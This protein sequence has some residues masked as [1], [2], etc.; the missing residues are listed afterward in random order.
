MSSPATINAS[1]FKILVV[2]EGGVGKTTFIKRHR[3]GEFEKKYVATMGVEVNPLHLNTSIGQI[4]FNSW[5]C[6]GQEKF[7]GLGSGYYKGAHAAI[8]MFDVTS[9]TSYKSVPFWY[10]SV[11]AVCPLIPIVLC[12][13]K[14]DCKDRKVKPSEIQFHRKKKIQYYDISA[15]SNYNFEKPFLYLARCLTGEGSLNFVESP[16]V[17]PPEVKVSASQLAE[18]VAAESKESAEWSDSGDCD[19]SSEWSTGGLGIGSEIEIRDAEIE[20]LKEKVR[21]L[22]EERDLARAIQAS[23]HKPTKQEV[24]NDLIEYWQEHGQSTKEILERSKK[25][26]NEKDRL[27]TEAEAEGKLYCWPVIVRTSYDEYEVQ[28]ICDSEEKAIDCMNSLAYGFA[29]QISGMV[30]VNKIPKNDPTCLIYND[31]E[32]TIIAR[33]LIRTL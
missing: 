19:S 3:T 14:I 1:R 31:D 33:T 21:I 10:N 24:A 4:V 9:R 11:R 6:A 32:D 22:Q 13:N 27:E 17:L 20:S 26:F 30:F 5:D 8:I 16:A 23:V 29:G 7:S 28:A 18:W 12:G 25:E 2:G 15:K